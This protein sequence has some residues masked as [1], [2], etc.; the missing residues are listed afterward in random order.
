MPLF[1][2]RHVMEEGLTPEMVA[3]LHS[4]DLKVQDKYGVKYLTYWWHE[5]A[6]AGFCLLEAPNK[7]AAEATHREAH[8]KVATHIIE[9]DWNSVEGFLGRVQIPASGEAWEAI[10]LKTILCVAINDLSDKASAYTSAVDFFGHA[11]RLAQKGFNARGGL[12]LSRSENPVVGCFPSV[13]AALECSLSVQK[14]FGSMALAFLDR[15]PGVEVRIGISAGEPVTRHMHLFGPTVAEAKALCAIAEPGK[16]LVS[17]PVRDLCERL[18]FKFSRER[19]S[20]VVGLDAPLRHHCLSGRKEE[21]SIKDEPFPFF[22]PASRYRRPSFPNHLSMREVEVLR[23]IS[24]GKT[25]QEIADLLFISL[26]TV[27]SHVRRIFDK[28]DVANRAEATSFAFRR[29]LA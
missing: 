8:G 7:D 29:R 20:V 5:G 3:Q 1:M 9:V 23:L 27:A 17:K 11:E 28:A 16:I 25:N 22:A 21:Q 18:G 13:P 26:S 12:N 4:C 10:A 6:S 14:S 19:A 24:A 15:R 2:D